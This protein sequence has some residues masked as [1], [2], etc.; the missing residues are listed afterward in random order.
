MTAPAYQRCFDAG[1]TATEAAQACG[2]TVGAVTSWAVRKGV[3]WPV[4]AKLPTSAL[5]DGMAALPPLNSLDLDAVAC[6]AL[7]ASV[8][9]DQWFWVFGGHSS[10]DAGTYR[11]EAV[12]WFRSRDCATVCSLAGIDYDYVMLKYRRKLAETGKATATLTQKPHYLKQRHRSQKV[13]A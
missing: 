3:F 5:P 8:L 10:D 4:R 7:W 13:A 9:R 12:V 11:Q 2:V 1:L 6:R